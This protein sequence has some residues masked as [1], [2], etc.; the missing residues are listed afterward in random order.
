MEKDNSVKTKKGGKLAVRIIVG[1]LLALVAIGLLVLCGYGHYQYIFIIETLFCAL[2]VHEIMHVSG[3]KNKVLTYTAMT[4]GGVI[5][6]IVAF[7]LGRFL[8]FSTNILI[9]IYVIAMLILMLKMYSVTRFEHVAIALFASLMI[10]EATSC[11]FRLFRFM[12]ERRVLFC[13]SNIVFTLLIVMFCAWLCDTFAL[14]TGMALGKHKMAPNISPK[15]TVEGAIGGII[16]TT[17]FSL[18]TFF[19]C[20]H[21]YFSTDTIR[22][23]MVLIA[24]P[25]ICVMGMCGDLS[26][27][28]IK[29]NYGFKDFGSL[30]PEHGGAMDRIDS[31]LFT[32]PSTYL[33]IKIIVSL[34]A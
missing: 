10:P 9:A 4:V 3:C 29:R 26:A 22:W 11:L 23:W 28:V 7:D 6:I 19:I 5:P 31:F 33:L 20:D 15:K 34:A 25:V 2:S 1:V 14:F 18:I 16:G 32:M 21:F 27:S 17:V 13:R 24:V 8:P 12:D 30:F